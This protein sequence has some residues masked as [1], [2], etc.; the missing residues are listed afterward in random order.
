MSD[1]KLFAK[2][3]ENEVNV[4]ALKIDI[5]ILESSKI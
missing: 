3:F 4:N 5:K 1:V 2:E